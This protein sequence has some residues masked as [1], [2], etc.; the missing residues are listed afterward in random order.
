MSKILPSHRKSGEKA[1][2]PVENSGAGDGGGSR[3]VL[4]KQL[5]AELPD[6]T[7]GIRLK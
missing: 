4:K 3:R 1:P 5:F 2:G 7:R 6:G